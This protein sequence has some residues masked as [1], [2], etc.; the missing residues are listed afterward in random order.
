[1]TTKEIEALLAKYYEGK[2]SLRE[3]YTL[4]AFFQGNDIPAHLKEHKAL[5]GLFTV[6]SKLSVSPEFDS[7]LSDRLNVDR[8]VG[9]HPSGR[10]WIWT[11]SLAASIILIAGMITIFKLGLFNTAQPYGTISDPQLA[12]A[13]ASNALYRMSSRFNSGLERMQRLESFNTGYVQALQLQNF[14]TGI[15]EMNKMTQL[16]KYQPINL[17]QNKP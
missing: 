1:M 9:F 5:F 3:E 16:D 15:D 6:E 13:E 10:G 12:Y 8:I 14:Q 2:T 17:T 4:K 11:L 7:S